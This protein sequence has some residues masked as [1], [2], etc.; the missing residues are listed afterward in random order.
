MGVN[1]W[2]LTMRINI[3]MGGQLDEH[4]LF[5]QPT[6][7]RILYVIALYLL[8]LNWDGNKIWWW[9]W[10]WYRSSPRGLKLSSNRRHRQDKTVLSCLVLS[11]SAVWTE[12]ATSQ[13]CRRQKISKLNMFSFYAFLSTLEIWCELSFDFC[14]YL[15]ANLQLGLW[16]GASNAAMDCESRPT[17]RIATWCEKCI[18]TASDSTIIPTIP[19]NAEDTV[20]EQDPASYL[21][22]F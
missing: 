5:W 13:D 14:L 7:S 17:R 20:F 2:I 4:L 19:E 1:V 16:F 8:F 22:M 21:I 10:W 9:W 3:I 11:V 6:I 18:A 15:V 12:L